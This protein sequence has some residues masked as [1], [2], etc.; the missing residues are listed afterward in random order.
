VIDCELVF[1][2]IFLVCRKVKTQKQAEV[3]TQQGAQ[4]VVTQVPMRIQPSRAPD[5]EEPLLNKEQ[6]ELVA[7]SLAKLQQEQERVTVPLFLR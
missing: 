7:S 3:A 6:A 4:R 1:Q 2:V 5:V